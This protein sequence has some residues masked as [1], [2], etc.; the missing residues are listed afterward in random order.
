MNTAELFFEPK[1]RL[2][3]TLPEDRSYLTVVP[4]WASPIS[5]PSRYLCLLDGKGTEIMLLP[6]LDSVSPL[7][8]QALETE[9]Q[10]R[11][12]TSMIHKITHAKVEF[13]A[14]YWHVITERGERELVTQSLQENAQ[15]LS[16]VHL[17][18]LDVDGN[19]FEIANINE[20]DPK[21]K[22][23]LEAIL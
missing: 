11:Y 16:D 15:W 2:R 17:V 23:Y 12:L 9:I 18:L 3:M 5:H 6:D 21:S 14:T 8:R 1:D 19:R 4:K 22:Q 13:G 7:A 10:R 20:L